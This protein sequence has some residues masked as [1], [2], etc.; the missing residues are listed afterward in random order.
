M[1]Y[2]VLLIFDTRKRGTLSMVNDMKYR[3][4]LLV[5]CHAAL[6]SAQQLTSWLNPGPYTKEAD[7]STIP[8]LSVGSSFE[9]H[10]TTPM[11]EYGVY[12]WQQDFND[13][14]P[15]CGQPIWCKLHF[16]EK[17]PTTSLTLY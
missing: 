6:L 7:L 3:V 5:A 17:V 14:F 16:L 15:I 2:N 10:W 12:L 9:T 4:G 11:Q 8:I 13:G 1:L